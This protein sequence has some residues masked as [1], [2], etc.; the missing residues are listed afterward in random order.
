MDDSN[1]V[2]DRAIA[3]QTRV[4]TVLYFARLKEALG[5]ESERVALPLGVHTV[6]GL[7][8]HLRARG[9]VWE[10]ELADGRIVRA[11][12]NHEM[13]EPDG[14]IGNGDEVALF[15]PVTGG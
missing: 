8:E 15:P 2:Q 13:A 3:S 12:V 14:V 11:A 6:V 1:L 9:G 5:R 7:R 4:V 10:R